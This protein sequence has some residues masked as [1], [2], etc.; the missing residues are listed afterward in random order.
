[1]RDEQTANMH[2]NKAHVLSANEGKQEG[3]DGVAAL[4]AGKEDDAE[5]EEKVEVRGELAIAAT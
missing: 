3:S 1:M 4:S 2:L 5:C